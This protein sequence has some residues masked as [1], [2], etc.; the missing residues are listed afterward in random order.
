VTDRDDV[1]HT[2]LTALTVGDRTV[3]VACRSRW[4]GIEFV[5]RLWFTDTTNAA[6]AI[7]DRGAMPGRTREEV[8]A[9]AQRLTSDELAARLA[10]AVA[11][12]R[13]HHELR[14]VTEQILAK[15]KYLNHV[16]R[17]MRSGLLD[18]DGATTE[19]TVVEEQLHTLVDELRH[20][21]GGES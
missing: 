2:D 20:H 10:R 19:M 18:V 11:E 17:S 12:K 14:S 3:T 1:V 15:I 4:D 13:R 6:P 8:I 5:G 21:A 16:A 9:L 7:P